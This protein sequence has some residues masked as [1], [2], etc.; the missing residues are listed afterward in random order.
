MYVLLNTEIMVDI[1]MFCMRICNYFSYF[2]LIFSLFF[3]GA[4]INLYMLCEHTTT[5]L[6]PKPPRSVMI[7]DY[8]I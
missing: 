8:I 3:Y 2:W 7:N 1:N 4:R 5:V 6:Y